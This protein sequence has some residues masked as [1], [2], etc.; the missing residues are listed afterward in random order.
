MKLILKYL[1]TFFLIVGAVNIHATPQVKVGE[2]QRILKALGY[3]PGL[4]DGV[5]GRK[6]K[7]AIVEYQKNTRMNQDGKVSLALLAMLNSPCKRFFIEG[8][9]VRRGACK[10]NEQKIQENEVWK[11]KPGQQA[12]EI[13]FDKR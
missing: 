6:T 3:N 1:V 9:P 4:V 10:K 7:G 13:I 5:M 12:I 8:H 11:A 2:V